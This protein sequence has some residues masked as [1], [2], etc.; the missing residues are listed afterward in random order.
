ML[1]YKK[2]N[3][4]GSL[5]FD[6]PAAGDY[7]VN[8]IDTPAETE[9]SDTRT[10]PVLSGETY[11]KTEQIN[12]LLQ[13]VDVAYDDVESGETKPLGYS[14]LLTVSAT[15]WIN[16]GFY[17]LDVSITGE[18]KD[19]FKVKVKSTYLHGVAGFLDLPLICTYCLFV[20]DNKGNVIGKYVFSIRVTKKT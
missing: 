11:G 7:G 19:Q 10:V 14:A 3:H 13:L 12:G 4:D 6:C 1:K 9:A 5:E 18:N 20:Y 17:D 8:F 16:R 15:E 2:F